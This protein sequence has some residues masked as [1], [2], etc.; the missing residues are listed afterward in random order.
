MGG[1]VGDNK[2]LCLSRNHKKWCSAYNNM[3]IDYFLVI[4]LKSV[5]VQFMCLCTLII[6]HFVVV[7]PGVFHAFKTFNVFILTS[8]ILAESQY[9]FQ[10]LLVKAF[11]FYKYL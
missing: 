3:K 5:W 4:I 1:K 2:T 9:I 8:A 7:C 11:N 10:L 6:M